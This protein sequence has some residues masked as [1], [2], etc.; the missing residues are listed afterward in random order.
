MS[1]CKKIMLALSCIF[2]WLV[3]AATALAETN[4]TIWCWDKHFNGAAAQMAVD[5][6][7]ESHNDVKVNIRIFERM[8]MYNELKTLLAQ[9]RYDALP[10]IFLMEDY[11]VHKYM[12]IY[13]AFFKD[14]SAFV[15]NDSFAPYKLAVSTLGERHFGVPFD[16]GIIATFIRLD[17][18]EMADYTL[19]DLQNLTWDEFIEIGRKV[20]AVTGTPLYSYDPNDISIFYAFM[21]STGT[22][23]TAKDGHRVTIS[24]NEALKEGFR[25]FKKMNQLGLL[26]TYTSWDN[27]LELYNSGKIAAIVQGGW[28]IP[29]L[30]TQKDN[31]DKWRMIPMPKLNL[32]NASHYSN[33]GGSQWYVNGKS[34]NA[35]AAA[36]FLAGTFINDRSLINQL[37]PKIG[38]IST[39]KDISRLPNYQKPER[40]FGNQL[41]FRHLTNWAENVPGV[42]YGNYTSNI[43]PIIRTALNQYLRGANLDDV[44]D[45]AQTEAEVMIS[46]LFADPAAS[47]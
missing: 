22:W 38:L 14:L 16:S 46:E 36:N 35:D 32:P 24:N 4:L 5:H 41:I 12:D 27:M 45:E 23:F 7:M 28:I 13:P 10:D 19:D 29:S 37:V 30:K 20:R 6:Y 39:I 34:P 18:F 40:F 26:R 33:L 17:L 8:D 3:S 42:N 43:D 11:Q 1:L 15:K 31:K 47:L 21:Q 9:G 44:L 25:V 2:L